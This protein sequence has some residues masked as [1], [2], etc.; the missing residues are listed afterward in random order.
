MYESLAKRNKSLQNQLLQVRKVEAIIL[1]N[2]IWLSNQNEV[3][4]RQPGVISYLN[5]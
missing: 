3:C 1:N 5:E 4:S 2:K